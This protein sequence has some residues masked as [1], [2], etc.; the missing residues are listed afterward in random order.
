MSNLTRGQLTEAIAGVGPM[1]TKTIVFD[2][3][4]TDGIG[5]IDGANNPVTL[6]KVTG[7]VAMRLFARCNEDLVGPSATVELGTATNT[8]ALIDVT[9]AE[10]LKEGLIWHDDAPANSIE[11]ASVL[12]DFILAEDLQLSVDEADVTAGELEFTAIW[13]PL[14]EGASVEAA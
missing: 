2:G 5:D 10:D 9:T 12:Q 3:G 1:A 13:K 8:N 11:Q 7:T 4:E 14:S 6:F